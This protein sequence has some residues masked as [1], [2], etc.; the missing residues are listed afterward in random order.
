MD[1][2]IRKIGTAGTH[3]TAMRAELIRK[4]YRDVASTFPCQQARFKRLPLVLGINP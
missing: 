1:K 4:S 2:A 3:E